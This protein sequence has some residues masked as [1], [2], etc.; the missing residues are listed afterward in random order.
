LLYILSYEDK[1]GIM[2]H[3]CLKVM[4]IIFAF[5]CWN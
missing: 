3:I 1:S 4:G 5:K 2:I